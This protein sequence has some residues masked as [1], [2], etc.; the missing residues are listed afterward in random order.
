MSELSPGE[1]KRAFFERITQEYRADLYRYA[2]WLAKDAALADDVVQEALLRAWRSL[3][4]LRSEQAAKTWLITIVRREFARVFERKRLD[5]QDI[6]T[7]SGTDE[8][9]FATGH[10]TDVD[11]MR[12]AI[13][14]LEADYREPLVLQVLLG[15]STE[16][17]ATAIGIKP[18]A[19]LTRL[20]R[21][22]KKLIAQMSES[23]KSLD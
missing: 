6:D 2:F 4:S 17:I 23:G 5:T 12:H 14:A 16:E 1:A 20:H 7:V 19:V 13:A 21:A 11:D 10:D 22:R 3:D 15:Y 8:A 18:G 9:S